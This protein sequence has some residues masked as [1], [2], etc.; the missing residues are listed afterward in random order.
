MTEVERLELLAAAK[1]VL[2]IGRDVHHPDVASLE[3]RGDGRACALGC[4]QLQDECQRLRGLCDSLEARVGQ[5]D[6]LTRRA[7][8]IG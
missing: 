8:K 7:E 1:R 6:L 2:G 5:S 3:R 4:W